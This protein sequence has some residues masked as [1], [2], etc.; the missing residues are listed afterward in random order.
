MTV[1]SYSPKKYASFNIQ[2][3][4][5]QNRAGNV[6]QRYFLSQKYGPLEHMAGSIIA[7]IPGRL[8]IWPGTYCIGD[9]A[10]ALSL[11]PRIWGIPTLIYVSVDVKQLSSLL[12]WLRRLAH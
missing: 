8:K 12:R 5:P 1:L 7:S 2:A 10:H 6:L 3:P 9:S 4:P 11:S